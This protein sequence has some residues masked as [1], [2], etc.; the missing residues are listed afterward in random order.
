VTQIKSKSIP[1]TDRGGPQ[2]CETSRLPHFLDNRLTDG[3]DVSLT[4]R[5]AALYPQEESLVLISVRGCVH[6]R[7]ILRLK[8]LG[9]L[10]NPLISP[11]IERAAF[12][13]IV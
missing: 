10:K 8:E 1:V 2:G 3:G 5:P 7:A 12:R 11:G 6:L 9:Q 4:C 13:I